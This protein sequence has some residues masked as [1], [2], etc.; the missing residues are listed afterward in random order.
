MFDQVRNNCSRSCEAVRP[1]PGQC[2]GYHLLPL[3]PKCCDLCYSWRNIFRILLHQVITFSMVE[4]AGQ[5]LPKVLSG[6]TDWRKE[7]KSESFPW[8]SGGRH[9]CCVKPLDRRP[10]SS[11]AWLQNEAQGRQHPAETQRIF[12]VFN[13]SLNLK[14]TGRDLKRSQQFKLFQGLEMLRNLVPDLYTW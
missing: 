6:Q 2:E 4:L 11:L 7:E 14:I 13:L 8:R 9:Q 10:V 12:T 1:A 5:L 3:W